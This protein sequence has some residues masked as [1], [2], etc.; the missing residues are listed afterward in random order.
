[1]EKS[2]LR[3][4]LAACVAGQN[5]RRLNAQYHLVCCV[6]I[7]G[8]PMS[9]GTTSAN[10]H[11]EINALMHA[12]KIGDLRNRIVDIV[13]L[14]FTK[15]SG[16]LAIARPCHYCLDLLRSLGIRYVYYSRRDG[17]IASERACDMTSNYI[18]YGYR[19]R[20]LFEK[21]N[22]KDIYGLCELRR[23]GATF[24]TRTHEVSQDIDTFG[25][26]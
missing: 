16:E 19:H 24:E 6:M 15:S 25:R 3:S 20:A 11:A 9:M 10:Y 21:K 17:T 1:M 23:N 26:P 2:L 22:E 4:F 14:R 8:V 7:D 5:Y 18:T 12:S 13:I